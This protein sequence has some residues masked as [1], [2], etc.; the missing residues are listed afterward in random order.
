MRHSV[1]WICVPGKQVKGGETLVYYVPFLIVL[2]LSACLGDFE[3]VRR[4]FAYPR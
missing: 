2:L 3:G 4:Q 1:R